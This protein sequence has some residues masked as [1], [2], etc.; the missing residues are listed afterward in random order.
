MTTKVEIVDTLRAMGLK[1]GDIVIVHSSLSSLG[2]VPGGAE[3]V[4]DAL[5]EAVGPDGT[6]VVPTFATPDPVFNP[7]SSPTTLG[8]VAEALRRRPGAVRS[9]SPVAS[10]AA[11]GPA[12]AEICA[13]HDRTPTAH[14]EGTPYWRIAERGGYVLLLGVDQDRNTMLHAAEE[15]TRAAYLTPITAN[16]SVHG[17]I[18]QVTYQLFPGPHRDFIGLDKELRR[19]G[20]VRL[21]TIGRA[22]VRLMPARALIEAVVELLRENP[23]A[24]LCDNPACEDC[25][26][27]RA[28]LRR[29]RLQQET[30]VI[31]A[32]SQLAGMYPAEIAD[33]VA[34]C[35]LDNLEVDLVLGRDLGRLTDGEFDSL[36]RELETRPLAVT[37]VRLRAVP[38]DLT[39]AC[40]RALLVGA[41]YLV[42]PSSAEADAL[43]AVQAA[44]LIPALENVA[45]GVGEMG[46]RLLAAQRF[47]TR[48]AFN[49]A[50]FARVGV[51]PFLQA[52]KR[53][54]RKFVGLL[55]VCDARFDGQPTALARGNGEIKEMISILRAGGFTGPMVLC[56]VPGTLE[57]CCGE[58]MNLLESL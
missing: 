29:S 10:V 27:Q 19:R 22:R 2:E 45:M 6:V 47:G 42:M 54:V 58:F 3:T 23:A 36:R 16:M 8:A 4:V 51:K 52:Y 30:F 17:E 57:T 13:G 44:G 24:V 9:L 41:K 39:L 37:S 43:A 50:E 48:C 56:G 5:L 21:G 49:P 20:I 1:A 35:G 53:P 33:R 46:R 7:E 26:R 11:L 40:Q 28:L 15:I 38:D 31:A 34:R 14:G 18:R 32:Q 55:Y 25:V 12:A